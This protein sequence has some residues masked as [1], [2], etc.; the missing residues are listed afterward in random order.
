MSKP[1]SLGA[2]ILAASQAAQ[3]ESGKIRARIRRLM[4]RYRAYRKLLIGEDG[5]LKPEAREVLADLIDVSDMD[6]VS[7]SLDPQVLADLNGARRIVMHIFGSLKLPEGQLDQ[8]E[9]DLGQM[10]SSEE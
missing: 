5:R 3:Q 7:R 1:Q 10:E 2:E 4:G 9:R 8:F 6:K